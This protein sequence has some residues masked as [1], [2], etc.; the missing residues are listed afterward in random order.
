MFNCLCYDVSFVSC[1]FM[2]T[3]L[4][5]AELLALLC[6]VSSCFLLTIPYGV[7]RQVWYLILS[8]PVM[9]LLPYSGYF[10]LNVSMNDCD[11]F[12]FFTVPWVDL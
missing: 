5:R 10:T 3:C 2:I 11:L 7:P 8:I 4:E 6:D 1:S 9:W 12:L